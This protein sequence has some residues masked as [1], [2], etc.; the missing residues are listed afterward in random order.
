MTGAPPS[1]ELLARFARLEEHA[2]YED[3]M[4]HVPDSRGPRDSIAKLVAV[5]FAILAVGLVST[6]ATVALCPPLGLL[7][8][9]LL[10]LVLFLY[11]G[12]VRESFRPEPS[13]VER[14][15]ARIVAVDTEVSGPGQQSSAKTDHRVSLE[16]RDGTRT[17]LS[18]SPEVIAR[19][20]P[21]DVGVAFRRTGTLVAFGKVPV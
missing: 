11:S 17:R 20:Q 1:P 5:L 18:A 21:D 13:P 15:P 2:A 12:Q 3:W 14:L 9:A 7:P 4:N 8:G 19:L 16:F 6:L 10:L